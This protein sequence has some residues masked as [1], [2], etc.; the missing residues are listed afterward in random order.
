MECADSKASLED[1]LK[2]ARGY[3]SEHLLKVTLVASASGV[4]LM[5]VPHDAKLKIEQLC[6]KHKVAMIWQT[7]NV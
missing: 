6:D 3:G 2:L 7:E 1:T 5:N 4:Q